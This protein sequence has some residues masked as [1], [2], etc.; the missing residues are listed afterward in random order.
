MSR[1]TCMWC[2]PHGLKLQLPVISFSTTTTI[3][4]TFQPSMLSTQAATSVQIFLE[5][6]FNMMLI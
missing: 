1:E 5:V 6:A 2:I 3:V 4:C